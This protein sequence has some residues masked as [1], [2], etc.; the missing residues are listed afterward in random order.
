MPS[1][2]LL[3]TAGQ[4]S[5]LY[6]SLCKTKFVRPDLSRQPSQPT[7]HEAK[8]AL[9][10]EWDDHLYAVHRRQWERNQKKKARRIAAIKQIAPKT[11]GN[12]PLPNRL[13]SLIDSGLWPTTPDRERA[14]NI[15]LTC[16]QK[17]HP[18]FR[19]RARPTLLV[20]TTVPYDSAT[21]G[22]ARRGVLVEVGSAGRNRARVG[23][24]HRRLRPWSD[25]AIVLDY[26]YENSPVI[27][28]VWRK[29]EPNTWMPCADTFDQFADML[30]LDSTPTVTPVS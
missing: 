9:L 12:L 1:P 30:G 15:S 17:T 13:I 16:H 26:R 6:C 21:H 27:R 24:R 7:A 28:L 10:K 3:A 20:S 19:T 4:P 14:Q 22:R 23:S 29:P 11:I 8:S 2:F 18:F 5:E 25:S